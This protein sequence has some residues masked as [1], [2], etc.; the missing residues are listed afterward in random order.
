[1]QYYQT[2]KI[3]VQS[4]LTAKTGRINLRIVQITGLSEYQSREKIKLL[5]C[6]KSDCQKKGGK[7]HRQK[8]EQSLAKRGLSC[9]VMIEETGCLGKCSLAPNIVL[10]PHKKRLSG[11]KPAA[12]ADYIANCLHSN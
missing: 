3:L 5:V 6:Q 10:M 11:L 2:V 1:L 9:R 8:L 7:H 4:K 12:I